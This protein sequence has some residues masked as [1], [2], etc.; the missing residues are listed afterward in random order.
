[1]RLAIKTLVP[2]ESGIVVGTWEIFKGLPEDEII[3]ESTTEDM[4]QS[5]DYP[6]LDTEPENS[7]S[8]FWNQ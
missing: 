7:G 8:D 4:T 5:S 6:L 3:Y 1:M 2:R